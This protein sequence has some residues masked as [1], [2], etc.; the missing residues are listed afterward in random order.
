MGSVAFSPDG[1][2]VVTTSG[3]GTARLWAW[4]S[5]PGSPTILRSG[6]QVPL[7]SAAFSPDGKFVATASQDGTVRIWDLYAPKAAAHAI[8]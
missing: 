2:L 6:N 4:K 3:D 8:R 1:E 7:S 5:N